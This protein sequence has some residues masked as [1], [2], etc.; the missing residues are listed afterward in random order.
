MSF[1]GQLELAFL[2]AGTFQTASP[3]RGTARAIVGLLTIY[4]RNLWEMVRASITTEWRSYRAW[5]LHDF[6]ATNLI[7]LRTDEVLT[8]GFESINDVNY[9]DWLLRH[10]AVPEG[11]EHT[12]RSVLCQFAYDACFAFEGGDAT[13]PRAGDK[14][15]RGSANMEAGTMLRGG[16]R[17]FLGYKGSIDWLFQVG[18]GDAL[19]A[20]M[21]ELLARRGVRFAFF[22]E[23]LGLDL[24]DGR[25]DV[26]SIRMERQVNLSVG[27]YQPLNVVK[28][29]PSWPSEPL[30]AQLREGAALQARRVNLESRCSDWKG[31]DLELRRGRDFDDVI[32]G[33]TIGALPALTGA[34]SAANPKWQA[35]LEGVKTTRT[36]GYQTWLNQSESQLGWSRGPIRSD[37][38][39]E[40]TCMEA[41]ATPVVAFEAWPAGAVPRNLTCFGGVMDDDPHEPP[42][43][44]PEYPETQDERVA[45]EARDF[46]DRHARHRLT[47]DGSG[48][49]NLYLAGAWIKTG[50]DCGCME[51]TVMSGMQASRALCGH[52]RVV[53]G[54]G[55]VSA[56]V[57]HAGTSAPGASGFVEF[58]R[59]LPDEERARLHASIP[60]LLG[61]VAHADGAFDRLERSAVAR[62]MDEQ[63][64]WRLGD[65]FRWSA[66]ARL[67]AGEKPSRSRSPARRFDRGRTEPPWRRC[68]RSPSRW[69]APATRVLRCAPLP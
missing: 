6:V 65:D 3:S 11:A 56:G 14:P 63:V 68:S 59:Q 5:I 64:R 48:F 33:I 2:L 25:G 41:E 24:D 39:C 22:H 54:E 15:L 10:A 67:D 44:A 36:F 9:S 1:V 4:L 58:C 27:E 26:E 18:R 8:L 29:V 66:A 47:A 7:G 23:V 50:L 57:V 42:S 60:M 43:P 35:M 13:S 30:Y 52:P 20:P 19:V 49:D 61:L 40:P 31:Q 45:A 62:V 34:P 46:L 32:L 16:S 38:G 12:V 37:T 55:A 51:A 21:Y 17:L 28:G 69:A 53:A